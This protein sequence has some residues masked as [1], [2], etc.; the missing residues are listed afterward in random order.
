M[1][2]LSLPVNHIDEIN[3]KILVIIPVYNPGEGITRCIE[4]LREQTLDDL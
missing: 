1:N 2:N 4:S 3:P